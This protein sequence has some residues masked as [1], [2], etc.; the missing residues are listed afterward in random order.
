MKYKAINRD[1]EEVEFNI[2]ANSIT[3]AKIYMSVIDP[4]NINYLVVADGKH[5]EVDKVK[6]VDN[7]LFKELEKRDKVCST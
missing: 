2:T 7:G 6:P 5:K 4:G 1:T 3:Q